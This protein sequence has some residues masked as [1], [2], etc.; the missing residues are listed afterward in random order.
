MHIMHVALGGCLKPPPVS[1]GITQDTGGHVAY[2]LGAASAQ[3]AGDAATRV[4]IVTRAFDDP[5]LGAEHAE[6]CQTFGERLC[7][8]R[9][10]TAR[11]GYLTK[12]GLTAELPALREAFLALLSD[13]VPD[14][15]HAHFADAAELALAAKRRYGVT[16]LYTPHS[17]ALDKRRCE[18][19]VTD[20]GDT[21]ARLDRE[22]RAIVESD[23]IVASSNDEVHRQVAAYDPSAVTRSH[24]VLPGVHLPSSA[25]TVLARALI[26]PFLEEPSRPLL[27]AIARPVPKKNLPCLIEAYGRSEPLRRRANLVVLAG[28]HERIRRERDEQTGE[29][30]R[31]FARVERHG[32]RGSVALPPAHSPETVTQLYRLA[33]RRGG[34][35]VNPARHEPFGL[36]LVEAARF[37]LPVVATRRGGPVDIVANLGHGRL[38]DPDD[39]AAIADAC[40]ELLSDADAYAVASRSGRHNGERYSWTRWAASVSAVISNLLGCREGEPA[41]ADF[42]PTGSSVASR[43]ARPSARSPVRPIGPSR[44]ARADDGMPGRA[45]CGMSIAL[46]DRAAPRRAITPP[47][48]FL[49]FDIDDTLTGCADGA[50]R[51]RR[52]IESRFPADL[53]YAVAT[54]RELTDAIAVVR[55]WRLPWPDVWL[56]SVGTEI[57]RPS[58]RGGL[59]RCHRWERHLSRGWDREA[60]LARLAGLDLCRQPKRTQRPWKISLFGPASTAT[61]LE[62]VL[63]ADAFEVRVIASHGR[64]IDIV[65]LRAGKAAAIEFEARGRGVP[66]S[67]CVAAGNSGND[68]DMLSRCGRAIL[69]ANALP[70]VSGLVD[71]AGL[72]RASTHC[73]NGVLEGLEWFG[74]GRPDATNA[75]A[76]GAPPEPASGSPGAASSAASGEDPVAGGVTG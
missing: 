51:F 39:H 19:G 43:T 5:D 13:D 53:P 40:L 61:A 28:Q 75:R 12:S 11:S 44:V 65:P 50:R 64:F 15:V 74:I 70:E 48:H 72:Y 30:E 27:L 69:V 71:R 32:L 76:D 56:T 68:A 57:W 1:Y 24:V 3:A 67:R 49:A 33:A 34:V 63:V 25:G 47:A 37:G 66:L 23:A 59:V 54:G 45:P 18:G 62:D 38:V 41:P 73:A 52:W 14:V 60:V 9:L 16:V 7:I 31:L 2:V 20:G 8:R 36:T 29:L 22:R 46:R 58:A 6:S 21:T 26:D 35:F 4:T 17:L 55:R 42:V 10:R